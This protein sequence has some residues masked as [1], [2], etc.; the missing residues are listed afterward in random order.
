MATWVIKTA[1][2]YERAY[3]A[4]K[5]KMD[6]VITSVNNAPFRA[7]ID[8]AIDWLG[9]AVEKAPLDTGDLR[10]SGYVLVNGE[11][12][13]HGNDDGSTTILSEPN[14]P[15]SNVTVVEIGFA[16][17]YA[18][19]QH[20]HVEFYHENG[21]AKYLEVVVVTRSEAA[22]EYLVNAV[23]DAIKGGV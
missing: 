1:A 11:L 14:I 17:S 13:A 19:V 7:I 4:I 21:E 16:S 22:R 18:F 15:Q 2:D 5:A 12:I 8:I 20:E 10:G 9:R 6:R 23:K 3:R